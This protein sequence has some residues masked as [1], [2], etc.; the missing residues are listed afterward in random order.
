M[1]SWNDQYLIFNDSIVQES[2]ARRE[3]LGKRLTSRASEARRQFTT[4]RYWTVDLSGL[5]LSE[6]QLEEIRALEAVNQFTEPVLLRL[7]S[8]C[9]LENAAHQAAPLGMGN[10]TLQTFPL[11]KSSSIQGRPARLDRI[12]W[13][14]YD[15]PALTDLNG[16]TWQPLPPLRIWQGAPPTVNLQTM[17]WTGTEI[18]SA[19]TIDRDFGRVTT[20]AIGQLW[21]TGGFYWR[22]VL[23]A[24]VP[25]TPMGAG[26][27]VVKEG[28][29]M[30]E[31]FP[32]GGEV[33]L[34]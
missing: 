9:T 5:Q 1:P 31:P 26:L 10:G 34:V 28:V 13:P 3:Y 19:C 27:F 4:R 18:T 8:Y 30:V 22:M 15:Y 6:A 12:Y 16:Q 20:S 11:L 21:A 33:A 23:P 24:G 14:N 7:S 25:I 29:Q 32:E 17:Q 2:V